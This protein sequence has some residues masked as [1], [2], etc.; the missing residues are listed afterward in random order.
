MKKSHI[1]CI[2]ALSLI[3][4]MMPSLA[5]SKG[6][7]KSKEKPK[8]Q[9][10]IF[11][12]KYIDGK[13]DNH[14]AFVNESEQSL[15]RVLESVEKINYEV[16]YRVS[17]TTNDGETNVKLFTTGSLGSGII[18]KKEYGKAYVITNNHVVTPHNPTIPGETL[19]PYKELKIEIVSQQIYIAKNIAQGFQPIQIPLKV[20]R[21]DQENDVALL[22]AEDSELL[23][24]YPYKIGKSKDLEAG[25]FLYIFG[26]PIGIEK[27]VLE[28]KVTKKNF[29]IPGETKSEWF[30]MD[31][32]ILPG[33]SGGPIIAI[34]DGEFEFVGI[35][36]AVLI[37]ETPGPQSVIPIADPLSGY[38]IA[39]KV[40]TIMELVSE[41]FQSDEYYKERNEYLQSLPPKKRKENPSEKDNQDIED[42]FFGNPLEPQQEGENYSEWI[43]D[44]KFTEL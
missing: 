7:Q 6:S 8:S 12:R 30:M 10:N 18:I 5:F 23:K 27:Y 22:Q 36:S 20:V 25:D 16:T 17:W 42:Q 9:I 28:G 2:L 38:S 4:P 21:R 29:S 44:E 13:Y 24:A 31:S 40:D 14:N 26:N 39:V 43:A 32:N 1:G 19:P 15:E 41:Y 34:R 35:T 3:A 37:R 11:V 33:S